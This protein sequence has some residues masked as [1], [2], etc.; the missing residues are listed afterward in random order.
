KAMHA[1]V[2]SSTLKD[3]DDRVRMVHG[4]AYA[5]FIAACAVFD[6]SLPLKEYWQWLAD[7]C[8]QG[9]AEIQENV[10]VDSFWRDLLNAWDSEHFVK[11][12]ER[13]SLFHVME[14]KGVKSPVSE[15]QTKAGADQPY[16][17]WKSYLLYFR[18]GPLI[19]ALRAYK[20]RSGG[21]LT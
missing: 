17:A 9:A 7:Y 10:Y 20:R 5:G 11:P 15:H 12:A 18:P 3:V 14:Q 16:K 4:V 2:K 21:D 13:R 6:V 19:E 1:W 8:R